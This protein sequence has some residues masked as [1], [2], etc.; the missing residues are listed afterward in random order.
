MAEKVA[1]TDEHL[2]AAFKIAVRNER[3]S[4]RRTTSVAARFVSLIAI[5]T[6]EKLHKLLP[7]QF[8]HQLNEE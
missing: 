6:A 4:I 3:R 5:S 8:V 2:S 1:A 7:E